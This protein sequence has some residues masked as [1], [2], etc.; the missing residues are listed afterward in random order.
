[1]YG[2]HKELC[3]PRASAIE[4]K[5]W[6]RGRSDTDGKENVTCKEPSKG[7]VVEAKPT[8]RKKELQARK[9]NTFTS[10][11]SVLLIGW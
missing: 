11:S 8:W 2:E 5:H 10:L 1:M 3:D 7:T 9:I 4:A 6:R